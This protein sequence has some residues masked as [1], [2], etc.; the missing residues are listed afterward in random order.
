MSRFSRLPIDTI[1]E[2]FN[3]LNWGDI[4]NFCLANPDICEDSRIKDYLKQ[5]IDIMTN[6]LVDMII[7]RKS[8]LPTINYI[9]KI[10]ELNSLD[11]DRTIIITHSYMDK[12]SYYILT[13]M[14]NVRI[15]N[16]NFAILRGQDSRIY[17]IKISESIQ[18]ESIEQLTE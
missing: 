10:L 16:Q 1:I 12:E 9:D 15:E 14:N 6:Q 11:E 3:R 2:M 5:R 8:S 7:K 13:E 17:K 4:Y 18:L